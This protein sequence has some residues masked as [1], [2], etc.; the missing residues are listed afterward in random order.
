MNLNITLALNNI[1]IILNNTNTYAFYNNLLAN[2]RTN[3]YIST[4][5][6]LKVSNQEINSILSLGNRGFLI[7]KNYKISHQKILNN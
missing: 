3:I 5:K 6:N 4:L 7:T 1:D 2:L